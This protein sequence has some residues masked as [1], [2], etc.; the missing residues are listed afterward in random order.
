MGWWKVIVRVSV[1]KPYQVAENVEYVY[2]TMSEAYEAA[3]RINEYA[4]LAGTDKSPRKVPLKAYLLN[5]ECYTILPE[6][7]HF[8]E[9]VNILPDPAVWSLT[10]SVRERDAD[11][12]A[13]GDLDVVIDTSPEPEEE[14]EI[15]S[16][17]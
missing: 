17:Q 9:V 7:I 13:E 2:K 11:E 16:S 10:A 4:S 12:Y 1:W 3:T 14:E 5:H 8:V 6:Y 15:A